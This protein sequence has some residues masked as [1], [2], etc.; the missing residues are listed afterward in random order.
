VAKRSGRHTL[1][2]RS[3]DGV[4]VW[5]DGKLVIENWMERGPADD[6]AAVDLETGKAYDLR[7]DYFYTG[8]TAELRLGWE[9]PDLPRETVPA[10]QL[11][12]P[13]GEAGGLRAEYYV[14][15]AFDVLHTTRKD[16]VDYTAKAGTALF[17]PAAWTPGPIAFEVDVTE[18][19]YRVDW[20]DPASGGRYA[21]PETVR[22]PGGPYAVKWPHLTD[23]LLL[24]LLPV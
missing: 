17:A 14:G 10:A 4:R 16:I 3:N 6:S 8:G 22:H 9:G 12:T 11:R 13:Q 20:I 1:H 15:R 2:T 19:E 24:R 23:D 18:G 5:L 7:V 21:H